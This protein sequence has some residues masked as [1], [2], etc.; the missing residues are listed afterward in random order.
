MLSAFKQR[1][2]HSF[3]TAAPGHVVEEL[4]LDKYKKSIFWSERMKI[5]LFIGEYHSVHVGAKEDLPI[6]VHDALSK[7]YPFFLGGKRGEQLSVRG[8]LQLLRASS[9]ETRA[10][11][12]GQFGPALGD[13]EGV[14]SRVYGLP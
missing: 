5:P 2:V 13:V 12:R 14:E 3:N 11:K 8:R 7:T 9:S 6:L 4:F 1:W 10:R